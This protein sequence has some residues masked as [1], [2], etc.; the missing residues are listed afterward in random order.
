V[1]GRVMIVDDVISAGTSVRESIALI[2]AAGATPCAV[3]IAL[4][5]Q[6]K[7]TDG[8]GEATW[9]A[10]QFVEA[11]LGLKAVSI[12]TLNDLLQYL[13]SG[14]DPALAAHVG[15]VAEYRRRYGV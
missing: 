11:Q 15:A 3:A 13:Q 6:E 4:D 9:S 7:A 5:R 2:R 10:V 8:V 14:R 12:A 1:R